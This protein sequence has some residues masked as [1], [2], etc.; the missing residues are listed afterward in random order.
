VRVSEALRAQ[1]LSFNARDQ[2]QR[3][4]LTIAGG[5]VFVPYG[6]HFGDCGD[7]HGWVVGVSIAN[8]EDVIA[9]HT[10]AN[11]GGVWAPGGVSLADEALFIATGNT[12]EAKEWGDGEAIIQLSFALKT[13]NRPTDYFTPRNW[14]ELDDRD[15]DLG[16]TNPMPIDLPGSAGTIPLLL[17]L[18]K[19]GKA[20]LLDR[21]NLGGIG[22][23]LV[24]E[25]VSS[26]AIR[27]APAAFPVGSSVFV[28]FAGQGSACP[29][30]AENV[31]LAVLKVAALPKPSVE[32]AWCGAVH[33]A[34]S[35][36]ATVSDEHGAD[37]IVWMLG[38]EGDDQL[39]GFR[40]DT[41]APL[42]GKGPRLEGLR[43]FGTIL[44][45]NGHLYVAGDGRIY[46][47]A[48]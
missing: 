3:G 9:W 15:A 37:P 29:G 27:T 22:G 17:A 13:S 12:L 20:Y 21:R 41:G 19:D 2:N 45:A 47:F 24:D 25:K 14:R 32:T 16:G 31:G 6:G 7:Y 23:A 39:H 43:H 46:A 36:I 10:R 35:P 11:G 38:S 44:A 34:G 42:T 40:G 30:R 26:R 28:A 8:P 1:N 5:R 48:F 33:G 18:G 4:A